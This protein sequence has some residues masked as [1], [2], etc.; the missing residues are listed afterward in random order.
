VVQR[1]WR[2]RFAGA[3]PPRSLDD[4]VRETRA[5]L[6]DAVAVREVADVPVGALLSG[7]IDS[8]TVVALLARRS[9]RPIQTFSVEMPGGGGEAQWARM[10]AA[11]YG[12][13]HHELTMQARMVDLLPELVARYGE[14]FADPSALP[15]FQLAELARRHVT[16]ALSGDGG[17]EAFG[18]YHRY[19]LE[20]LARRVGELPWPVPNLVHAVM[21]RLP[22]ARLRPAREFA[23]H[24]WRSPVERYLF[25]LAHFSRRDKERLLGPALAGRATRDEVAAELGRVLATSDAEDAVNRLL[26]LDTQTYLPDDIFTKV[27]I[28][29]MAHA[30]EVRAPFVDHLL[31]ESLARLP[32]SVKLRRFTGKHLLR[33]AVRDLLPVPILKRA[34]RGF[35]LPLDRWM[36]D[37]LAE[38]TRDLLTDTTARA[39]GLFDER[40]VR[41]LLDEHAN[42]V[43]HGQRLWN[44]CVLELWL[45]AF[46]D[47]APAAGRR[48]A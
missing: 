16:V 42:G 27:D 8:S 2:L 38:L 48:C 10:V 39:R 12:T 40:E 17:D 23:S 47:S 32:G 30:V 5:L 14:P 37:E 36:R 3:S 9:S 1:W 41:R 45:R 43:S 13:D 28:A 19:A 34:K 35:N 44:L 15:T 11:R 6:E 20:E 26:D 18:G 24:H 33:L 29:S 46:V 4:A 22:G 21:R 25:L 31:L 7:G